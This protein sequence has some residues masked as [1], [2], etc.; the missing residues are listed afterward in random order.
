MLRLAI[1]AY[2][3]VYVVALATVN[4]QMFTVAKHPWHGYTVQARSAG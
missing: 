4:L 3:G 2:V 1:T